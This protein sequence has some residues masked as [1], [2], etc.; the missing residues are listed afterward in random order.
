MQTQTPKPKRIGRPKLTKGEAKGKIVALRF[1]PDELKRID[2][3]AKTRKQTR[4][5]WIRGTLLATSGG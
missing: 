3:A 2:A 5:E 4:S 1:D